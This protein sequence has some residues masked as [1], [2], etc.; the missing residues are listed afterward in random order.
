[1]SAKL[2]EAYFQLSLK[3]DGFETGIRKGTDKLKKAAD[4]AAKSQEAAAKKA[5]AAQVKA[6]ERAAIAAEKAAKRKAEAEERAAQRAIES[7]KKQKAQAGLNLFRQG[8]DVFSSAAGGMPLG[9]IAAQQGPQ[10][11]D[12]LATS[13]VRLTAVMGVAAA[14]LTAFGVAAAIVAGEVSRVDADLKTFSAQLIANADGANYNA[15]ALAEVA[16]SFDEMGA[17]AEDARSEVSLFVRQGIRPDRL[18]EFGRAARDLSKVMGVDLLDA[19]NMVATAFSGNF[20]AI[21]KLDGQINFLTDSELKHIESLFKSGKAAEA[22][23]E[24]FRLFSERYAKAYNESLSEADRLTGS[25]SSAWGNLVKAM[26]NTGPIEGATEKIGGLV[27]NLTLWLNQYAAAKTLSFSDASIESARVLKDMAKR[28]QVIDK[29]PSV[30][31]LAL[32]HSQATMAGQILKPGEAESIWR[33]RRE[34]EQAAD[35][36]RL[37]DLGT[38]LTNT[39]GTGDTVIKPTGGGGGTG[40]GKTTRKATEYPVPLWMQRADTKNYYEIVVGPLEQAKVKLDDLN[41]EIERSDGL[42]DPWLQ[43][44]EQ[45]ENALISVGQAAGDAFGDAIAY[46]EDFGDAMEREFRRMVAS[47]ASSGFRDL[48]EAISGL[49]VN[50]DGAKTGGGFGSFLKSF[51][52]DQRGGSSGGIG[53]ILRGL[54]GIFKSF[55]GGGYTGS[56]ARSG[57]LDG[58]GGFLAMMHPKEIVSDL[59]RGGFGGQPQAIR[60]EVVGSDDF[61]TKVTRIST[62]QAQRY[63]GAS[64]AASTRDSAAA[65]P[66]VMRSN[67]LLE[68]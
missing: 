20:D 66:G 41:V 53:G 25:L 52:P 54:G 45:V 51:M 23:N 58:K 49:D 61:Y 19:A 6:A 24:A 18:E 2:G 35:R 46:G 57:G 47:Y 15:S 55:D 27:R 59:T 9:M 64:Y 62:S 10:I 13:G 22:R 37:D 65:T 56:G 67:Q 34:Q 5:E 43:K 32:I 38:V 26:A 4:D 40:G 8:S 11:L 42:M 21:K 68:G 3:D 39:S 29:G 17:S 36:A 33:Y 50:G 44:I 1:M 28:Q 63:A 7:A 16:R 60:V 14:G 30:G 12:A 31:D 48:L